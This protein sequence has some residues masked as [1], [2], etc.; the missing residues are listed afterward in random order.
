MRI[1]GLK[2][3]E[4][5]NS[6]TMATVKQTYAQVNVRRAQMIIIE[7][8]RGRWECVMCGCAMCELSVVSAG[9]EGSHLVHCTRSV[10]PTHEISPQK[11]TPS[12]WG[13]C[14]DVML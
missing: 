14:V 1:L 13:W 6:V 3:P 9:G 4:N 7:C 2:I 5:Y 10:H 8:V 12:V 11:G